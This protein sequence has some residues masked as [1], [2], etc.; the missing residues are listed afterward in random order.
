MEIRA[1]L[2][3]PTAPATPGVGRSGRR[4]LTSSATPLVWDAA[5]CSQAAV[6]NKRRRLCRGKRIGI[7]G[8]CSPRS[9]ASFRRLSCLTAR[10]NHFPNSRHSESEAPAKRTM[11]SR[12]R[13]R[14]T[15][16]GGEGR[17]S[18]VCVRGGFRSCRCSA[19]FS[20]FIGDVREIQLP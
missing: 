11:S 2:K 5:A 14:P 7:P 4:P 13:P 1:S 10:L 6:G 20:I 15:R 12:E 9:F 8:R 19:D 16:G 3:G 17:L 18:D